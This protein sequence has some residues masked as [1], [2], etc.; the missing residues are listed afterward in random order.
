M[1]P[2]IEN[3]RDMNSLCRLWY[4]NSIES[5]DALLYTAETS[6]I[7]ACLVNKLPFS[8][9]PWK[10]NLE[11]SKG[12]IRSHWFL[13]E[14]TRKKA[15]WFTARPLR[16]FA[17]IYL[18]NTF[19]IISVEMYGTREFFR[20]NLW[21]AENCDSHQPNRFNMRGTSVLKLLQIRTR[22]IGDAFESDLNI[23]C[24]FFNGNSLWSD[25][26]W[27]MYRSGRVYT[28]LWGAFELQI[29][30]IA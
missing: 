20:W 14:F 13:I 27:N 11:P 8:A 12:S 28:I 5:T 6:N 7:F 24:G 25:A 15:C 1:D 22:P 9:H 29:A 3:Q 26:L 17:D 19:P 30:S 10:T 2:C 23:F 4:G 21:T 16:N 18:E